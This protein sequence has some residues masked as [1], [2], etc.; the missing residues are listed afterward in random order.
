MRS[1]GSAIRP[2]RSDLTTVARPSCRWRR[3]VSA[4]GGGSTARRG[5]WPGRSWSRSSA[6]APTASR[7]RAPSSVRVA[8]A[9]GNTCRSTRSGPPR[10][11]SSSAR[12]R[13]RSRPWSPGGRASAIAIARSWRWGPA[14]RWGS[15]RDGRARSSTSPRALCSARRWRARCRRCARWRADSRRASRSTFRPAPRGCKSTSPTPTRP[16]PPTP[17]ARSIASVPP[18]WSAW[19]SAAS[20]RSAAPRSTSP[21]RAGRRWRFRPAASRRSGAPPTPR[22]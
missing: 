20:R 14:G 22:W 19:R 2:T 1:A 16:A 13:H 17:A 18:G 7:R 8:A 4:C 12:W 21:S 15:T 5:G 11:A 3:R 10:R 6:R 9:S